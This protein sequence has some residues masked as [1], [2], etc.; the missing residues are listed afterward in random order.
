MRVTLVARAHD[1]HGGGPRRPGADPV[2]R[3]LALGQRK[4]LRVSPP[5]RVRAADAGAVDVLV[6]GTDRGAMGADGRPGHRT[7]HR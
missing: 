6:R 3:Q 1:R 7:F 5:V 4:H 2:L